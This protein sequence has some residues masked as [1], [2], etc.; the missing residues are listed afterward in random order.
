MA[1]VVEQVG[2][3]IAAAK[4]PAAVYGHSMGAVIGY[5]TCLWLRRK[6]SSAPLVLFAGARRA[7]HLEPVRAPT[8]HL[9]DE[10][11]LASIHGSPLEQVFR[12]PGPQARLL[13]RTYRADIRLLEEHRTQSEPPLAT[14]VVGL[15][16]RA[17]PSVAVADV[18]AWQLLTTSFQLRLVDG[19][20]LF[21]PGPPADLAAALVTELPLRTGQA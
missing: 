20:H 9:T 15:L 14:P 19:G 16:G 17:D 7:P 4:A 5:E 13:L 12:T 6:G 8:S 3:R 11:F 1:A 21:T 10:E 18:Q 2:H